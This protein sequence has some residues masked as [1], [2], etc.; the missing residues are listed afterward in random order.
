MKAKT[1]KILS[2]V[3]D[4][5]LIAIVFAITDHLMIKVIQSEN[6]WLELGIYIVLYAIVFGSKSGIMYLWKRHKR[7]K[8]ENSDRQ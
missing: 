4:I 3:V 2:I 8:E 7:S 5:I 6:L 1:Q